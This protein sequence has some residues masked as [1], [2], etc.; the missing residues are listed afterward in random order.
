MYIYTSNCINTWTIKCTIIMRIFRENTFFKKIIFS[1]FFQ[2]K[3]DEVTNKFLDKKRYVQSYQPKQPLT[4]VNVHEG[5]KSS[6]SVHH[7]SYKSPKKRRHEE[8]DLNLT[9]DEMS[10]NTINK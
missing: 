10:V 2:E 8:A 7:E 4:T 3:T 1:L 9:E 6:K 5:Y